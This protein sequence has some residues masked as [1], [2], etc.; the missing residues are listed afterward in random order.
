[1]EL[2]EEFLLVNETDMDLRGKS[3]WKTIQW[4]LSLWYHEKINASQWCSYGPD[5]EPLLNFV[6][7]I[8][9][10]IVPTKS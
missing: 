7:P 9:S 3:S 4:S 5:R 2:F 1:M 8:L 10:P 6:L